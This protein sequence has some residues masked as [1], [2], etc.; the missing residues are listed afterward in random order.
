MKRLHVAAA[1]FALLLIPALASAAPRGGRATP[2]EILRNPR[3][4]AHYLNLSAT[5]VTQEQALF[6]TLDEALRAIH[7]QEETQ[8]D[9]LPGRARQAEPQ[10]PARRAATWWPCTDSTRMRKMRCTP[11]TPRSPPSSRPSSSP[12][13]TR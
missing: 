11:S 9:H 6:K 7:Q 8:R 3:L 5:Q 4:L 1:A 2:E 13:T 10:T 12:S